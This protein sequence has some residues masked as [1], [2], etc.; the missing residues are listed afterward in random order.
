MKLK[1]V[2]SHLPA[3]QRILLSFD[4]QDDSNGTR[5][6]VE[7]ILTYAQPAVLAEKVEVVYE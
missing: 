1:K 3:N 4:K 6:A 2:I 7:K 5:R